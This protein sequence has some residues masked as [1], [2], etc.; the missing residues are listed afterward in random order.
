MAVNIRDGHDTHVIS[1]IIAYKLNEDENVKR[2]E[3]L[4]VQLHI[5][6]SN[7]GRIVFIFYLNASIGNK[8]DETIYHW[9]T[10]GRYLVRQ[11]Q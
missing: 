3:K 11:L 4:Y 5:L 2:E 9:Q 8:L 6:G 7:T 1:L 10:W